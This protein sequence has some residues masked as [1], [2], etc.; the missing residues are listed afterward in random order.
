[1]KKQY[2]EY[3]ML[4]KNIF[5]AFL[6]SVIISAIA[7]QIFS[8]QAKYINS[9][10][11]LVV[12]LSVYYAAFSGFFYIDNRKKYL[13]ESGKL[14]KSRLK[15]DLLKIIASLGSS[16]IIYVICRWLIQYYLLTSNYEAYLSSALAQS[17]SFIVY[18][19]CVNLIAKSIR[20]YKEKN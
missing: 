15:T 20:L 7:S 18:L 17:I 10:A 4:N 14:D 5:L 19:V 13:L 2:K 1:M 12:D 6:T 9:S 11:T 3:V 16:E 8:I